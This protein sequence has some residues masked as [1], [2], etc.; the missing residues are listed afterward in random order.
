MEIVDKIRELI[1]PVLDESNVR[2]YEI[3][4]ISN[5]HTLQISIM[6]EDG[7]MDL[8]TCAEVSEKISEVLDRDDPIHSE[9]TLEVC[10]PGAEREIKDLSELDHMAGSYVFVRLK[11]PYK[12][13]TE[14]TGEIKSVENNVITLEYRDKAAKRTAVF[15]RDN[16][17]YIR[18]A[19]KI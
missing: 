16:I 11:E 1:G 17:Q 18:M 5:E 14:F 15:T 7:S 19:V 3:S 13:K 10:S 6:K 8:D 4:W 9:Y 2:L 12:K